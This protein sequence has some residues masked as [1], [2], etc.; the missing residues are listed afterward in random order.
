MFHSRKG[1]IFWFAVVLV[2]LGGN[3]SARACD[4]C[5]LHPPAED[6]GSVSTAAGTTLKRGR[7]ALGFTFEH[8]K[9][10]ELGHRNAHELHEEGRDIHNFDHDE[11]YHVALSYGLT[12]DLEVGLTMPIAQKTFLRVEDG[13][14]GRGDD[15]EGAGDLSMV[16]KYRIYQGIADLAVLGGV[17]FP[18]GDTAQ[19]GF[20]GKKLE[21]EEVPGTGSFD[22]L[23]GA[24]VGKKMGRWTVGSDLI[25]HVKTEGAQQYE[26]GD[27]LRVDLA[28]SYAL[29]EVG[30]FPNVR[31]TGELNAQFLDKDR[32][33]TGKVFDSGGQVF[34]LTP[35][36]SVDLTKHMAA[37]FSVPVPVYQNRGGEH[38]EIKYGL[39]TGFSWH[40]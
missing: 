25:Y 16:G 32:S 9:W 3:P 7:F 14:V 12:D 11:F 35:G 24:A 15:S 28:T 26:F 40:F 17:K 10:D 38:S 36:V 19:R 2:I 23:L 8:R 6:T 30:Q 37:F 39:I 29:R 27:V 34:F 31:L 33:R 22:Y 18:T 4:V 1:C 13:V 5:A 21:P 20:D